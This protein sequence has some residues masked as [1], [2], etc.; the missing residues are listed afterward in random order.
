[1]NE[2]QFLISLIRRMQHDD[3][4]QHYID[5]IIKR[6]EFLNNE[7]NEIAKTVLDIKEQ[8]ENKSNLP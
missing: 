6:I 3:L 1:M 2:K 7:T 8:K 4:A 5:V